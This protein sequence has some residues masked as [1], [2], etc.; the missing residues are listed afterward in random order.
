MSPA[1]T[2]KEAT[3]AAPAAGAPSSPGARPVLGRV[4]APSTD[5]TE[6]TEGNLFR[7]SVPS[8]WRELPGTNAV[9]FA[10]DGA[11]GDANGQTVLTH[12]MEIGFVGTETPNVRT[13]TDE[14]I[15][16]LTAG[17]PRLSRPSRYDAV[18]IAGRPGL[19]TILSNVSDATGQQERIEVYTR[20]VGD[21]GLL[22]ALGV[23]PRDSF[24]A[25]QATFRRVVG[26]IQLNEENPALESPAAIP[27][28]AGRPAMTRS[29]SPA[30]RGFT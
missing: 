29:P 23:A 14:F 4:A 25:Y 26:S 8:N 27:A 1:P 17:N 20:L 15:G 22:Y 28:W 5:Y 9:T 21:G 7:V 13:A 30:G 6:Y 10:P 2:T 24:S 3:R 19:H 16:S 12:G 11:H 18:S